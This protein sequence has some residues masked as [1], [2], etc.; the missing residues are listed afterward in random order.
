MLL[1]LYSAEHG[2]EPQRIGVDSAYPCSLL[3]LK[4]FDRFIWQYAYL[5]RLDIKE[6][7]KILIVAVKIP[8]ID[9]CFVT[10]SFALASGVTSR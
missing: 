8:E 3:L 5:K 10:T 9:T 4:A 2:L 1:W 7:F 6:L